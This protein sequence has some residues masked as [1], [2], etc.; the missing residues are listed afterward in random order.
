MDGYFAGFVSRGSRTEGSWSSDDNT[1]VLDLL[2]QVDFV[3]GGVLDEAIEVG[4]GVA[5]LHECGRG[6][7]EE[8]GLRAN[9]GHVGCEAAGGEHDGYQLT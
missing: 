1:L 9:A 4:D 3:S 6:A 8:G 2:G 7:V 5:L